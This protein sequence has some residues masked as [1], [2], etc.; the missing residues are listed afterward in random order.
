VTNLN[1]NPQ[2]TLEQ[3]RHEADTYRQLQPI[4]TRDLEQLFNA[5][6]AILEIARNW[7]IGSTEKPRALK[8]NAV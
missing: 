1:A 6:K 7:S 3:L 4:R 5:F 2:M 8:R